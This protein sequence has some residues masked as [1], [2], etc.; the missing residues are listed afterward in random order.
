MM[1]PAEAVSETIK[2]ARR[3]NRATDIYVARGELLI[4]LCRWHGVGLTNRGFMGVVCIGGR[5]DGREVCVTQLSLGCCE[6]SECLNDGWC[7]NTNGGRRIRLSYESGRRLYEGYLDI[8][9]AKDL[10][11]FSRT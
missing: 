6:R 2:Q 9:L 8:W 7:S 10:T 5:T 4:V 11:A 3:I 1:V